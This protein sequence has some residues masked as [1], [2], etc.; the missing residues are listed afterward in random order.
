MTALLTVGALLQILLLALVLRNPFRRDTILKIL[1]SQAVNRLIFFLAA[2][3]FLRKILS[4]GE[5]DFG[6]Y[7]IFLFFLFALLAISALF[8]NYGF[9]AVRGLVILQL[10]WA[11][12]LLRTGLGH[13]SLPWLL[14]K[15]ATYGFI[16][17]ALYLAV[18]PYRLRDW[19][20]WR[21]RR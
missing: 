5:A 21:A 1:H 11:N 4:L 3:A 13:Y 15:F 20:C 12:A 8:A 9:L 6:N 16:L 18:Y 17:F 7:R 10:L 19:L 14:L 2:T